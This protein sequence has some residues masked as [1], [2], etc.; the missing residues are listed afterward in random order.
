MKKALV[1]L[2]FG[3]M[4]AGCESPKARQIEALKADVRAR[5]HRYEELML[6]MDIPGLTAMFA[7][8][9][10]M[11]NPKR[12]PVHG[13]DAISRFLN[14]YADFKVLANVDTP[15]STLIDGDTAEQIGTYRQKV[16][17]PEGKEF[18]TSGRLEI[19]WARSPSG[20][21]L[22]VQMATFPGE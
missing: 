2:I 3:L 8:E 21:W 1:F 9:G 10:E 5:L 22:I 17:S 4:A 11:V 12:P 18:E 6:A 7:P 13:R 19:E 16:R 20:E 14:E 15:T